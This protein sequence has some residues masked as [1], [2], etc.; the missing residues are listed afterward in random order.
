MIK[1]VGVRFRNA[2]KIYYFG[3]GN[4]DLTAG[5]HVIVETARGVELGTVMIPTREVNDDSVIQ[6]LKPVIRIATEADE[7][8]ALKNREKEKEAF[9]ICLEKIAKH[10]LDMKLVE[11]E[12]SFEGNKVLFFFTAEGAVGYCREEEQ[13]EE[14]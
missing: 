13:K 5:M 11:A 2:G 1:I 9:K 4:L 12:Y 7:K 8:T 6:P 10:K 14:E 3:P